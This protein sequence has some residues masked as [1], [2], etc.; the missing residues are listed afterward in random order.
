MTEP[1]VKYTDKS[2]AAGWK[3][4]GLLVIGT[5]AGTILAMLGYGELEKHGMK[6]FSDFKSPILFGIGALLFLGCLATLII[7]QWWI[8]LWFIRRIHNILLRLA[9]IYVPLSRGL[10]PSSR[11]AVSEL[12][13]VGVSSGLPSISA[14]DWYKRKVPFASFQYLASSLREKHIPNTNTKNSDVVIIR[15]EYGSRVFGPYLKL[16]K[17]GRYIAVFR[18]RKCDIKQE[19]NNRLDFDVALFD[20]QQNKC[21]KIAEVLVQDHHLSEEYKGIVVPFIITES[22]KYV[23]FRV[24]TANAQSIELLLDRISVVWLGKC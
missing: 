17:L 24:K 14:R 11:L 15:C 20:D 2:Q 23:E 16:P 8:I 1:Q 22:Q 18:I 5:C 9:P 6:A 21:T 12:M 3:G 13:A 7:K 10:W 4:F 19:S